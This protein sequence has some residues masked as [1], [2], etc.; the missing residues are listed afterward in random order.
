[1]I[2]GYLNRKLGFKEFKKL[3]IGTPVY[4]Q[5]VVYYVWQEHES[6]TYCEMVR[7]YKESLTPAINFQT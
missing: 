5:G 6:G 1:M 4:E 3:E 2:I 7:Y